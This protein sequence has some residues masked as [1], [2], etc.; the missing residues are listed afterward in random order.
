[1]APDAIASSRASCT[2]SGFSI[3]SLSTGVSVSIVLEE[4]AVTDARMGILSVRGVP[5]PRPDNV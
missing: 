4:A 2:V 5:V 1:M 3:T